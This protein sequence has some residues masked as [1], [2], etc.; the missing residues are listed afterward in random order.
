MTILNHLKLTAFLIACAGSISAADSAKSRKARKKNQTQTVEQNTMTPHPMI[1]PN[2]HPIP[3]P[4]YQSP[5][6]PAEKAAID[7]AKEKARYHAMATEHNAQLHKDLE[8]RKEQLNSLSHPIWPETQQRGSAD[9]MITCP[10][11]DEDMMMFVV[12]VI[13]GSSQLQSQSLNIGKERRSEENF[14]MALLKA[15]TGYR[16][17]LTPVSRAQKAIDYLTAY[18]QGIRY[19]P[20]GQQFVNPLTGYQM[21]FV[22]SFNHELGTPLPGSLDDDG[23]Q[24]IHVALPRYRHDSLQNNNYTVNGKD[25]Y[26]IFGR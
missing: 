2:S 21:L 26:F 16:I 17:Y 19:N 6:S 15:N 10:Q 22:A 25:P 14:G 9:L 1:A 24:T 7:E 5:H 3:S 20:L 23:L 11:Y 12:S 13:P 8:M 4:L 18:V